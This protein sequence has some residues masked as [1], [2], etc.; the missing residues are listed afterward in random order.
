MKFFLIALLLTASISGFA[1]KSENTCLD[2]QNPISF[3]DN[4]II[5]QGEKIALGPKAFFID[6]QQSKEEASKFPYVYN[7]IN[8]AAKHLTDGTE[9]SPMVLYIAPYVYWIDNPDDTIVRVP[10]AGAAAPY[11]L[12]IECEWLKFYGLTNNPENVVLACNRG[13]TIG[14]RGNF[15]MFK[16]TG[17]GTSSENLTFGN[18]CNVDL[19]YPLK[20]NLNKP[21]RASAIVQAQLIHCNGDKI[22]A[23]NTRF[24][25]RLNLCPFVGGKRVLFDRCHFE[26]TDDALCGTGV[27]LNCT[28]DFYSSK[29][30]YNTVGTGAVFL[31]CDIQSFTSGKQFFTKAGGQMAVVDSRI[32]SK[33]ATYI[34]WQDVPPAETRNYQFNNSFNGKPLFIGSNDSSLTVDM[35][36]DYVSNAFFFEH[37]G[38]KIYN[39][40][41]LLGGIDDWDPMNIKD[42]VKAAEREHGQKLTSNP[43]QLKITPTNVT[44]E[45]Q[46]NS[47]TLSANQYLFGNYECAGEPLSWSLAP[48]DKPFVKLKVN[49][50]NSTC[51]VI[52]TNETDEP[53]RVIVIAKTLSGLEAASVVNV[54]PLMLDAPKFRTLPSIVNKNGKLTAT[55]TLDTKYIDQSIVSWFRFTDAKGSNPIET[56][57]SRLNKPLL[58][59]ELSA[60]DIGYYIMISVAPKHTRCNAGNAVTYITPK[61][62]S[63]KDVK[64]DPK[65]LSTDFK[66][67]SVKNQPEI[68]P[69]FWSWSNFESSGNDAWYYGEGM[70]G[71]ANEVGLLQGRSARMSYTPVGNK[72]GDMKLSMT[73]DPFKTAGQGFSV[74]G[75]YMDILIKFD[76]KTK[77]GYGLRFIRTTKYG[78]AVD[79]IF[80]KYEKGTVSEISKP[81]STSCYR[82]TCYITLEV[83]GNK[84]TAHAKSENGNTESVSTEV[85]P[86]INMGTEIKPNEYGGFGIEYNGG[87]PTMI[88]DIRVEWQ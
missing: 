69:G 88:K 17:E 52:P 53:H 50:D 59:Y 28:L 27:Y 86:E 38:K 34:G 87:A 3:H 37:N 77:T 75:L 45:T 65:V 29:P 51:E 55:Y 12:E 80:V 31:N 13:Q 39:T 60:G 54:S 26:S 22:V 61:P 48:A 19:V 82:P 58:E 78:N 10:K 79:C 35:T 64:S 32:S 33:T 16:F 46:K 62:I 41:N 70:D 21:K 42:S 24:I 73:V 9:L 15:T 36:E 72:F 57:V 2:P 23:R 8:E 85:L 47:T 6:G 43:V 63:A 81:V 14:A 49:N 71:A 40:Y 56:A 66:N 25:S 44:I 20:P 11:G 74:A 84:I 5:Y 4:Y 7:S 67:I 83:K 30:F 68:I 76:A 1:Q 18:Y